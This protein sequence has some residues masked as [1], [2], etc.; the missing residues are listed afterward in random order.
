M[1]AFINYWFNKA[2]EVRRMVKI[3]REFLTQIFQREHKIMLEFYQGKR[4]FKKTYQ[5]LEKIKEHNVHKILDDYFYGVCYEYY[6]RQMH[7]WI[8]LKH[9]YLRTSQVEI[10]DRR[11]LYQDLSSNLQAMSS[12]SFKEERKAQTASF[13]IYFTRE[14]SEPILTMS[15]NISAKIT[16]LIRGTTESSLV[17][18]LTDENIS[19]VQHPEIDQVE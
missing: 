14:E 15:E 4:K 7:I 17:G 1:R 5:K 9:K 16:S 2:R 8:L 18:L 6:K 11:F 3:K 10:D 19:I 12:D 13:P